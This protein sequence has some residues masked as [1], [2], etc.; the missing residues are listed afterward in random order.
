MNKYFEELNRK[1]IEFETK[2]YELRKRKDECIKKE[3]WEGHSKCYEE[4]EKLEKENPLTNGEYKALRMVA[5]SEGEELILS[6]FLWENEI[7][8]FCK[9]LRNGE[10]ESFICTNSSTALMENIHGILKNGFEFDG[11]AEIEREVFRDWK[12]TIK[13]LRFRV[14]GR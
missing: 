6:D 2:R 1:A 8:D 3:D 5:Y 12:E 9:A 7:E 14:K 13:G 10:V 11:L 4:M